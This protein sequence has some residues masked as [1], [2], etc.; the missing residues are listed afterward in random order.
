MNLLARGNRKLHKTVFSWSITPVKSCPNHMECA[1]YCYAR[2]PYRFYKYT[3]IAWDRNFE[4][5]KT[6]EFVDHIITQLKRAMNCKIVRIHVSGDF[7]NQKYV[8][9]WTKIT[10]MFPDIK[11]YGYTKTF[12]LF[13]F[14]ELTSL[15]NVN[16]INSIC[17]D[18][19]INFGDKDRVKFLTDNGYIVCPVTV[20]ENKNKKITCGKDCNICIYNDK[21][22]FYKHK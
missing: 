12:H 8:D 5:A 21:V 1:K 22:C 20:P 10:K 17:F 11:F 9:N 19:G 6:G 16:I 15:E 13:D 2:F 14:T 18:G 3:K 7:F 4:F